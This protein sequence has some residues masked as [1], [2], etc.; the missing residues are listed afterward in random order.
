[1]R[2]TTD[3]DR[4]TAWRRLPALLLPALL[5][6]A[7]TGCDALFGSVLPPGPNLDLPID[8]LTETQLALHNSGDNN[9]GT[10]FSPATGLGPVYNAPSCDSCHPN[11]DKGNPVFHFVRFGRGDP[12]S[13]LTFDYLPE[14]GGPQLH[15]RAIPGYP[16]DVLPP[17]VA[18][19]LRVGP[20]VAGLG[21]LEAVPT[22]TILALAERDDAMADGIT[23][24]PNYVT[25]P[26]FLNVDPACDCDGCRVFPDGCRVMG[27][28]G[29][30][31][32]N[33]SLL[34][35]A[36]NALHDDIGVTSDYLPVKDYNPEVGGPAGDDMLDPDV[37]EDF[38]N[39]IVFYLRTLR[40]PTRTNPDDP[41]VMRGELV[42]A[43]IGCVSCHIPTLETGPSTIAVLANQTIHPYTDLLL[44]D[45]GDELADGVPDALASGGQWRTTPLWGLGNISAQLGGQ[46]FYLHDG[47]ARS[48]EEAVN[49]HGGEALSR[50]QAF[51][52]IS[53]E[54]RASV[55]AFLHS[56]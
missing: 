36:A 31:A 52:G 11:N 56:L 37:N 24:Q 38:V 5:L 51:F 27:R 1:L 3:L 50:K 30:K 45:M 19:S 16:P 6:P 26:A 35:Q 49:A 33:I 34:M 25:P 39:D 12:T 4:A 15:D 2:R 18:T 43:E 21:L 22:A 32:R 28:F 44:H 13:E 40:P 46:E 20:V 8:G 53:S 10:L 47:R 41:E 17:D 29:R 48:V 9:F 7:L 42:F 54:A 23:G 55:V 14:L